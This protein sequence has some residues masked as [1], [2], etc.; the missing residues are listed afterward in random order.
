MIEYIGEKV[1]VRIG[2]EHATTAHI[3]SLPDRKFMFDAV[4]DEWTRNVAKD[5]EKVKHERKEAK[6]ILGKYNQKK[7]EFDDGPFKTPAEQYA[8]DKV[9]NGEPLSA[10][11][12]KPKLELVKPVKSKLIKLFK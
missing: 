7:A 1:E 2:L 4:L 5:N 8:V 6:A 11:E 9:V 10:T 3:F 12:D